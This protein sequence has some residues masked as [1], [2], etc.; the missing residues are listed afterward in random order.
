MRKALNLLKTLQ[1]DVITAE[2]IYS[3][4]DS[5]RISNLESLFAALQFKQRLPQLLVFIEKEELHHPAKLD[6]GDLNL[7]TPLCHPIDADVLEQQLATY[8]MSD[9]QA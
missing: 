2:F 9:S 7:T 1:P 4:M 8:A 3:P 6:S 5:A